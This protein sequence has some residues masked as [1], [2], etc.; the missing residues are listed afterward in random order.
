MNV[1]Q[2][3]FLSFCNTLLDVLAGS[4][5]LTEPMFLRFSTFF[6][7]GDLYGPRFGLHLTSERFSQGKAWLSMGHFQFR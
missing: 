3:F 4:L 6:P 2:R 5:A 7:D 1:F